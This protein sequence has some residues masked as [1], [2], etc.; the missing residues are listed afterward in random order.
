MGEDTIKKSV[1]V[2]K[3]DKTFIENEINNF[4]GEVRRFLGLEKLARSDRY[5]LDKVKEEIKEIKEIGKEERQNWKENRKELLQEY[6][7]EEKEVTRQGIH[8]ETSE[9]LYTVTWQGEVLAGERDIEVTEDLDELGSKLTEEWQ[10]RVDKQF[11]RIGE[12]SDFVHH[13]GHERGSIQVKEDNGLKINVNYLG[14]NLPDVI[15]PD[16]DTGR[17]YTGKK[18]LNYRAVY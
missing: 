5:D 12:S 4:S 18:V 2:P 1:D 11:E 16:G 7:A 13:E 15:I 8:I 3:K 9:G 10:N 14:T 6:D 17:T